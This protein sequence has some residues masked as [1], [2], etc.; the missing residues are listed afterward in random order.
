MF[1]VVSSETVCKTD[2]AVKSISAF[3]APRGS[4]SAKIFSALMTIMSVA[5]VLGSFRWYAVGDASAVQSLL[6]QV[7]FS[8]LSLVAACELD[9]VPAKFFEDKLLVSNVT[10]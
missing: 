2:F 6:S 9:V 10:Y 4:S 7:G 8:A 1:C 5:G 3:V